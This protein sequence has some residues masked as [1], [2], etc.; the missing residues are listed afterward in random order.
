MRNFYVLAAVLEYIEENICEDF[1]LQMVADHCAVSLSGLH[2]LFGYAFGYSIKDY[3]AKRRHSLACS[4]LINSKLSVLEI[5]VKYRYN[6]QEVF[7]RA[8]T[9]LRGIT[10]SA[11]RNNPY[12]SNLFPKIELNNGGNDMRKVDISDMYDEIKKLRGSYVLCSDI[13]HF[14]QI[15]D[16]FGFSV[17]DIVLA[18]TAQRID[19]CIDDNMIFF[20]IGRDEFAVL[21]GFTDEGKAIELAKRIT[22]LNSHELEINE[23]KVL[24]NLRVG[25]T[26]IPDQGLSYSEILNSMLDSIE[27]ARSEKASYCVSY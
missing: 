17:G 27:K 2:K 10:P 24:L 12:L 26:K 16:N 21:T 14:K 11:Y 23:H 9:R 13:V 3:I 1:T 7:V 15:N 5:A 19:S 6:S 20:R 22:D 18:K 4:D 8:F 25:V